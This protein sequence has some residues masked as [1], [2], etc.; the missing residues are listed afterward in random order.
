MV[1]ESEASLRRDP[2]W[3]AVWAL[4]IVTATTVLWFIFIALLPVLP[5]F[6]ASAVFG[7]TATC[8]MIA[9]WLSPRPFSLESAS[10]SVAMGLLGGLPPIALVLFL[11]L[12]ETD[13][14]VINVFGLPWSAPWEELLRWGSGVLCLLAPFVLFG[15]VRRPALRAAAVAMLGYWGVVAF[16]T[17]VLLFL[18]F[19]GD[20]AP[21]CLS[22]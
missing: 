17:L 5:A 11:R 9:V 22:T 7:G 8:V 18:S 15:A 13:C 20:P 21:G 6:L 16:P 2:T 4:V 1:A 10:V 3:I 19:Y 12:V 14:I